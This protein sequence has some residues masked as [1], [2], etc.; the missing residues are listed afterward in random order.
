MKSKKV[1]RPWKVILFYKKT[2]DIL[3]S[4]KDELRSFQH[5]LQVRCSPRLGVSGASGVRNWLVSKLWSHGAVQGASFA[6]LGPKSKTPNI[7]KTASSLRA[8]FLR[9]F[10]YFRVFFHVSEC[11]FVASCETAIPESSTRW[12]RHRQVTAVHACDHRISS[13]ASARCSNHDGALDAV[14]LRPPKD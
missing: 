7:S 8:Y 11:V 13:W 6:H 12:H 14:R 1:K 9:I 3:N 4:V 10:P 2:L 5:F